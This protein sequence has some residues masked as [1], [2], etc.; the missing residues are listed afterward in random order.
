[1][2]PNEAWAYILSQL[3]PIL[4]YMCPMRTFHIKNYRQHWM[5]DELIEQIKDRDYYYKKAKSE[6]C[7]DSWNIAKYQHKASK[8]GL[9]INIL[10]ELKENEN[11]YKK[12]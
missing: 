1:M 11:D 10:N 12:F 8:K 9:I 2:D 7:E 5:T 6:G 4:D 3:T